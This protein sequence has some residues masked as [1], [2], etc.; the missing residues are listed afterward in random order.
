MFIAA[1]ASRGDAHG[2]TETAK[3]VHHKPVHDPREESTPLLPFDLDQETVT[4]GRYECTFNLCCS[5]FNFDLIGWERAG[6]NVRGSQ[7]AVH[8]CRTGR[9]MGV[10]TRPQLSSTCFNL[11]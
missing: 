7:L 6:S 5:S 9:E 3:P 2:D 4:R 8:L 11:L 10:S 1:R